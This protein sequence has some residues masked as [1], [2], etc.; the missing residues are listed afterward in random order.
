MTEI[1]A[2][3]HLTSSWRLT[4]LRLGKKTRLP[5][6]TAAFSFFCSTAVMHR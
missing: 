4:S 3:A 2:K 5:S 6:F 1:E